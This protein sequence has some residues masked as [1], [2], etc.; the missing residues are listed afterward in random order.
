[1]RTDGNFLI[2]F[3][4]LIAGGDDTCVKSFYD[5]LDVRTRF[6]AKAFY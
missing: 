4:S 3:S 6:L 2:K 1:M 5:H